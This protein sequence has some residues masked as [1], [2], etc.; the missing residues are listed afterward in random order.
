MIVKTYRY[1][2]LYADDE[3]L[4]VRFVSGTEEEH[5]KFIQALKDDDR[6]INATRVY[7]HEIDINHVE[8]YE[9]IVYKEEKT[10]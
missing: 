1:M 9:N 2:W 7:V 3:K 10:R 5:E 8:V 6:I 4:N